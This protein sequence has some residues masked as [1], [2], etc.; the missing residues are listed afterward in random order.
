[1]IVQQNA[2]TLAEV[3]QAIII[4]LAYSVLFERQGELFIA[5]GKLHSTAGYAC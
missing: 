3:S 5:D 1:L 2:Q 4:H